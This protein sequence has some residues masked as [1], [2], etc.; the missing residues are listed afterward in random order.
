MLTGE[1]LMA[2][3]DEAAVIAQV[4][5]GE[6]SGPRTRR[7]EV[8]PEL[9]AIVMQA[10][11]KDVAKR[12]ATAGEMASALSRLGPA[13]HDEVAAFV[14][15]F[16]HEELA[17]RRSLVRSEAVTD[18][19][20]PLEEVLAGIDRERERLPR[21]LSEQ[22]VTRVLAPFMIRKP[23]LTSGRATLSPQRRALESV[24]LVVVIALGIVMI[25]RALSAPATS[26]AAL[27]VTAAS[28]PPASLER[29]SVAP[30]SAALAP[31]L[32]ADVSTASV[33]SAPTPAVERR[34]VHPRPRSTPK[35]RSS[36]DPRDRP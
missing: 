26:P 24:A 28:P 2:A 1:R 7:S 27:V 35:E 21:G 15:D 20:R 19:F 12:Y 14:R 18:D 34:A 10:L 25:W 32:T 9:D 8:S 5:L 17:E 11:T 13:S 4:I 23:S 16:A 30:A 29:A 22:G 3:N 36:D 6:L 33:V 31:V